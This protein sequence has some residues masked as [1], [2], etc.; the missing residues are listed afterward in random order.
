VRWTTKPWHVLGT[1][2]KTARACRRQALDCLVAGA[3]NL[4]YLPIRRVG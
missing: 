2:P 4:I 1:V 3:G